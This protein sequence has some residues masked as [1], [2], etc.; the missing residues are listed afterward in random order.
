MSDEKKELQKKYVEL[1]MIDAQINQIQ[2]QIQMLD[3][4]LMELEMINV[5]L[6]DFGNISAGTEILTS[7]APGIYTK[8]ELKDND[9]L[10][11]NVGSN[12][13]VKKNVAETK[14]MINHQL[15]EM[16]KLQEQIIAELN[17]LILKAGSIEQEINSAISGKE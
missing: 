10:I 4:Q 16:R 17:K 13:V 14:K 7:L 3:N 6:D 1:Q 12:I 5:S 11:V 2:K 8:A 15:G 9:E